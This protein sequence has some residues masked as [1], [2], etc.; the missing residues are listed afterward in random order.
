MTYTNSFGHMVPSDLVDA[1]R[2]DMDHQDPPGIPVGVE[3]VSPGDCTLYID[4]PGMICLE[5]P[6]EVFRFFELEITV[7]SEDLADLIDRWTQAHAVT[8]GGRTFYRFRA[9]G[10]CLVVD[11]VNRDELLNL[12]RARITVAEERT[13]VFYASRETPQE[14]LSRYKRGLGIRVEPRA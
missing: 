8:W 13:A 11:V 7:P 9:N 12:L 10:R 3:E 6:N 2:A 14:S 1:V 4:Q 5:R